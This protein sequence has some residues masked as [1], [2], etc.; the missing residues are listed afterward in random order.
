[1]LGWRFQAC[2]P[3]QGSDGWSSVEDCTWGHSYTLVSTAPWSIQ[4]IAV[5]SVCRQKPYNICLFSAP[6]WVKFSAS[7][8]VVSGLRIAFFF[9]TFYLWSTFFCKKKIH[10]DK[11]HFIFGPFYNQNLSPSLSLSLTHTHTYIQRV[12][13]WLEHKR[14]DI[15]VQRELLSG[16][17]RW[18]CR[19]QSNNSVLTLTLK[20]VVGIRDAMKLMKNANA[21]STVSVWFVHSGQ[22]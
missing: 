4:G 16:V 10:T 14:T 7:C 19:L 11:F 1:M 3:W 21:P 20:S 22:L 17:F 15:K 12:A 8:R 18:S 6:D 9:S 2:G 5:C 13:L